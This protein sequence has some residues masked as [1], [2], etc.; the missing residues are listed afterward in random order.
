MDDE[1]LVSQISVTSPSYFSIT[2]SSARDDA[3][4]NAAR[5]MRALFSILL[6]SNIPGPRLLRLQT[7]FSDRLGQGGEGTV[8]SASEQY[9]ARLLRSSPSMDESGQISAQVWMNR[10]V[11]RLR[12]DNSRPYADQVRAAYSEIKRLCDDSFRKHPN[13]VKLQGWGICLDSLE[14]QQQALSLMPLL[15]LERA[16]CDLE[17]F[18]RDA[19]YENLSYE[20]LCNL[21]R[22][23]GKGLEIVHRN[24]IAHGDMKPANVLL[25]PTN[26]H[27]VQGRK[28]WTAKLC[29][30]GSA[31][32][33]THGISLPF[34]KRGSYHYWPPEYWHAE[35][36]IGAMAP[37]S[38]QA[39][40]IFAYGLVIWNLFSGIPF[41]PLSI[42]DTR[43]IALGKYGRQEYYLRAS[44]SIRC[45]YDAESHQQ[46]LCLIDSGVL[47][48]SFLSGRVYQAIQ[49]QRYHRLRR[50]NN[51]NLG[52]S[53]KKAMDLEINRV[54]IVLRECL[55]DFPEQRGRT[56]WRYFNTAFYSDI[57][58]GLVDTRF[59]SF[60]PV[61]DRG[62]TRQRPTDWLSS[63]L[64]VAGK[65]FSKIVL[66]GL[67]FV[68]LFGKILT[69]ISDRFERQLKSWLESWNRRS[70]RQK[71]YEKL[72]NRLREYL[73][74]GPNPQDQEILA[75]NHERGCYDLK[76]LHQ[77]LSDIVSSIPTPSE[78]LGDRR[79]AFFRLRSRLQLCCWQNL[80]TFASAKIMEYFHFWISLA[81]LP[82][83]AWS[84]HGEIGQNDLEHLQTK[85]AAAIWSTLLNNAGHLD[86]TDLSLRVLLLFERG[87]SLQ[88]EYDTWI[89]N[90]IPDASTTSKFLHF[91]R[92][93]LDDKTESWTSSFLTGSGVDKSD[94]LGE[95]PSPSTT[96]LHE[97]V[98]AS[99]YAVVEYLVLTGFYVQ[100]RDK[101]GKSALDLAVES[102]HAGRA[103]KPIENEQIIALLQQNKYIS[104][105]PG[106]LNAGFPL[107]WEP[108][109][110]HNSLIACTD[111]PL[112]AWRETSVE[113][114]HDAITFTQPKAGL[115]Q[116]R[117]IELGQSRAQGITGQ[118]YYLDPM[119]FLRNPRRRF[120]KLKTPTKPYF[121]DI[122]YANDIKQ[123]LE[124]PP[125]SLVDALA[126]QKPWLKDLFRLWLTFK[127]AIS[128]S[129]GN[130]LLLVLPFAVLSR[131]IHWSR[132]AQLIGLTFIARK[133][134]DLAKN[135][136]IGSILAHYLLALGL[137]G[138]VNGY[139]SREAFFGSGLRI[140]AA[141][142]LLAFN[143]ST[144]LCV[145]VESVSTESSA[146]IL[147]NNVLLSRGVAIIAILLWSGF[148]FLRFQTHALL[149][150]EN[151]RF[152]DDERVP[153]VSRPTI[154]PTLGP[155]PR[156]VAL[157]FYLAILMLFVGSFVVTLIQFS[158][159]IQAKFCTFA[160]PLLIRPMS[161]VDI[162]I[163]AR[164]QWIN[165]AVETSLRTGLCTALAVAPTLV[166]VGWMLSQPMTLAF[167]TAQ[168][169]AYGVS[170]WFV[171]IFIHGNR[172]NYLKGVLLVSIYILVALALGISMK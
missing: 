17:Q 156:V 75:H 105:G 53:T 145:F 62:A 146:E 114:D 140:M 157:V 108:C 42:E 106:S 172:T 96:A 30:F 21:G 41:P 69:V 10:V 76:A 83:L 67:R 117:R 87:C 161:Y 153:K 58:S 14:N 165:S 160:V 144:M 70:A 119:R 137:V 57:P 123:N 171:I 60:V 112:Q 138:L 107:G 79:Y 128:S 65:R 110:D 101:D 150:D 155:I 43:E 7:E 18:I 78:A 64:E 77:E 135:I 167:S 27:L 22:D 169:A 95:E 28:S 132:E 74:I 48:A 166:I 118:V 16:A 131:F 55:N 141:L 126:D 148:L 11:K 13:I 37:E 24:S 92:V 44:Q 72:C 89:S 158:P 32:I 143:L 36:S 71:S 47:A 122:W 61:T 111:P 50:V 162:L 125:L 129:Y 73:P 139:Y 63:H 29:D 134:L 49:R 99:N 109:I 33:E 159:Q 115:W 164:L 1:T 170:I 91:K 127:V 31:A 25:F 154:W 124:P 113:S 12:S 149:F 97:A 26:E 147:H 46:I 130:I 38:L 23:I 59:Q 66:P 35:N 85:G 68:N 8:Y 19:E 3:P 88:L 4:V 2:S 52:I 121:G 93:A 81:D 142:S 82:T 94:E 15:I 86:D 100:A 168:T 104:H 80:G 54:L 136:L 151:D 84:L 133:Q 5:D 34:Q 98:K 152:Y 120:D 9:A 102:L 163:Y 45:L 39:C 116:D 90:A 51:I 20:D 56:P 6:Q 40:D 103:R